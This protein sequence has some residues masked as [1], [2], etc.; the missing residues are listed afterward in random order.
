MVAHEFQTNVHPDGTLHL[1]EDV[2]RQ[3]PTGQKVRVLILVAESDEDRDWQQLAT[4]QFMKGY[5]DGDAIYDQLST[6]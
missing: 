3:L 5:A 2:A 6:G 4:E 1:P